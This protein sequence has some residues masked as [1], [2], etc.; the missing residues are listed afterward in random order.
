M[1]TDK[2]NYKTIGSNWE[3]SLPFSQKCSTHNTVAEINLMSNDDIKF[4]VPFEVFD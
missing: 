1:K 4:V 2:S 3:E